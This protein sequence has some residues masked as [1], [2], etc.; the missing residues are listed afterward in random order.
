MQFGFVTVIPKYLN[1]VTFAKDLLAT[2]IM[3]L[4]YILVTRHKHILSFLHVYF[5]TN[6]HLPLIQFLYFYL[7]IDVL[8]Q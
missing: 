4:F 8:N 5:Y 2:L 3:I 1:F 7:W 6:L